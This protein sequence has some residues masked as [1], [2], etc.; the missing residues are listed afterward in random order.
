MLCNKRL[1]LSFPHFTA[2][3]A[4]RIRKLIQAPNTFEGLRNRHGFYQHPESLLRNETRLSN[5]GS[6]YTKTDKT[7][8]TNL[9]YQTSLIRFRSR[10]IVEFNCWWDLELNSPAIILRDWRRWH[11]KVSFPSKLSL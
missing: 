1:F 4:G 8:R 11:W 7:S 3:G 5:R 10:A 2:C 9:I 6:E